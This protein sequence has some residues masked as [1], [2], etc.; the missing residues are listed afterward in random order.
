[1]DPS[2]WSYRGTYDN[3]NDSTDPTVAHG[4]N[5]HQGPEWVWVQGYFLRAYLYF[6]TVAPGHDPKE[7]FLTIVYLLIP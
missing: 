5:Y 1:M 4:F 2:D 3:T 6:F 7:V